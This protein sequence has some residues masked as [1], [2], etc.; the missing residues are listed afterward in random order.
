MSPSSSHSNWKKKVTKVAKVTTAAL[1]AYAAKK[2]YDHL[3]K[4]KKK[5]V[6]SHPKQHS[7]PPK[8]D[9]ERMKA[10]KKLVS[11]INKDHQTPED[12]KQVWRSPYYSDAEKKYFAK[13]AEL[14]A[15]KQDTMKS[16][17]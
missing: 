5:E 8:R 13:L 17:S 1:G 2:A 14:K 6:A 9:E 3:Q 11:L 10:D 12:L 15:Q 7:H 4:S 16:S